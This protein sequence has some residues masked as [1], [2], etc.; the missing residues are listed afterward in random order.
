M[1]STAGFR[2]SLIEPRRNRKFLFVE[3]LSRKYPSGIVAGIAGGHH[4]ILA[5]LALVRPGDAH[6]ADEALPGVVEK[7]EHAGRDLDHGRAVIG[8]IRVGIG[9]E[10]RGV[11]GDHEG[12][13]I[14]QLFEDR[15]PVRPLGPGIGQA[16]A[17]AV[18]RHGA[19]IV[20]KHLDPAH[21]VEIVVDRCNGRVLGHAVKEF[22]C[23]DRRLDL[24]GDRDRIEG[25]SRNLGPRRY[26]E[27]ENEGYSG[28]D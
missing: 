22:Q 3:G 17:H 19:D 16:L 26:G 6:I 13:R 23:A 10:R 11:G 14:H 18:H 9:V 12:L 8:E 21:P 2:P 25:R 28:S 27:D 4:Q 24:V 20:E 7:A 15:D 1:F 5:A